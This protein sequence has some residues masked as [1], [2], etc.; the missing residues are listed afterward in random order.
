M[1]SSEMKEYLCQ[2]HLPQLLES[3]LTGVLY[4]HPDDPVSFLQSCLI[5]TRQLGGPE[6]VTWD[7]F[8]QPDRRQ[9]SP[10]P[11]EPAPEPPRTVSSVP[12]T[13]PQIPPKIAPIPSTP[14]VPPKIAL[15]P[16]PSTPS[17]PP[18][19]ALAPIPSIPSV[20]P[21]IALAPIPSTPSV[22]P[23][24]ALAPIPSTP[25]VPPKIALAP[26]PSIP[27]VPPKIALAPIPSTPSNKTFQL[28]NIP[29][30]PN[31]T[32]NSSY[33]STTPHNKPHTLYNIT[34]TSNNTINISYN[35]IIPQTT[36]SIPRTTAPV[37]QTTTMVSSIIKTTPPGTSPT[38]PEPRFL[39]VPPPGPAVTPS[40][41]SVRK[42][43]GDT[44]T[45][46][47]VGPPSGPPPPRVQS[48]VSIDSDSD[49]TETS[50]LLQE[51]SIP[52]P[53]RPR[54]LIIFII[55][56]PASGKGS[57]AARLAHYFRFRVISLDELLRRQL[58]SPASPSKKWEVLSEMMGHGELGPQVR[59]NQEETVSEL[60]HHLIGQ[61]E[62][63]GVIVDGFPQ[64]VHQALSFQEQ[65][66]SPDLVVLLLC[67]NQTLRCRLQKR[68]ALLGLLGDNSSA[69]RR[70]LETFQR[71]IV[72][73]SRYYRQLHLLIQVDADREEDVVL[74]DLCSAIRGKLCLQDVSDPADDPECSSSVPVTPK[75]PV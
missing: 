34:S 58:L 72:S 40:V 2:H 16:I 39:P 56:G 32:S 18:K 26:I 28:Y 52:P 8:I 61:K 66:G 74:A 30:N 55:G 43:E 49:M 12:P 60:S 7:T 25:S 41:H 48:Q 17:V 35:T 11:F 57:Q 62:V 22:P 70:R 47:T 13:T 44:K 24:I 50:G 69:L 54:P 33:N 51:V 5:R 37:P 10:T 3:L 6:A 65:T 45:F 71:D 31:N 36:P 75:T 38:A 73:I 27:S 46:I 9:L 42:D 64:D 68:A 67:S 14:S 4:H 29:N 23:K 15:A 1:S 20:P 63:R 19:I 53:Q 21:K 59:T